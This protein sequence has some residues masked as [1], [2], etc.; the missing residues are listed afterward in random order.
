MGTNN[1]GHK[2]AAAH[3]DLTNGPAHRTM[4]MVLLLKVWIHINSAVIS[5]NLIP[6]KARNDN[7]QKVVPVIA[8]AF[9]NACFFLMLAV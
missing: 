9:K 2:S 3:F 6:V 4:G 8:F 1:S 5:Y 7:L